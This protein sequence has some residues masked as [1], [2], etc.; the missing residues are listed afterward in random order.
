[1]FCSVEDLSCIFQ[2]CFHPTSCHGGVK[3]IGQH[4]KTGKDLLEQVNGVPDINHI[5]TFCHN[6][7]FQQYCQNGQV[8]VLYMPETLAMG[9]AIARYYSSKLWGG[10][11]YY[12]QIDSHLHFAQRDRHGFPVGRILHR[13]RTTCP[14]SSLPLKKPI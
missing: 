9:P 1:M 6:Q 3:V 11:T 8:R 7:T 2:S 13:R 10:E 12:V 5:I 4:P 14:A